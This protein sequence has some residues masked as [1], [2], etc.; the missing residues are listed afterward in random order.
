[1]STGQ[2]W[3]DK[4]GDKSTHGS[5]SAPVVQVTPWVRY[6]PGI[7]GTLLG[8]RMAQHI[9]WAHAGDREWAAHT[10]VQTL[11]RESSAMP[12]LSMEPLSAHGQLPGDQSNGK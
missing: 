7:M 11:D 3:A 4:D 12:E 6:V 2:S 1:M 8:A 9:S 10:L 5:C